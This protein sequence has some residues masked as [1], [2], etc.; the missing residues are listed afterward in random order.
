MSQWHRDPVYVKN[1]RL[2]R[3]ILT[4]QI[5]A[6]E[7]VRCVD[8]GRPI[9]DGQRWDVGHIVAPR[10][11]GTHDPSNLGASHRR[12]NR[13]AGG[14]VGAAVTNRGSRRA[15]RLPSW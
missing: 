2:V 10:D 9:H 14:R 7:Y 4:P 8:C 1:S 15:R 12:C 5:E 11:G 3:R 6:G 13:T